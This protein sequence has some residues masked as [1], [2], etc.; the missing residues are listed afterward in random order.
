MQLIDSANEESNL[1][2]L[3]QMCLQ[4][5]DSAYGDDAGSIF[6]S[7]RFGCDLQ[8]PLVKE[9][10]DQMAMLYEEAE[11]YVAMLEWMNSIMNCL[12][13][14]F[15]SNAE[16]PLAPAGYY[17]RTRIIVLSSMP[18]DG[19]VESSLLYQGPAVFGEDPDQPAHLMSSDD[20][21]SRYSIA[22]FWGVTSFLLTFFTLCICCPGCFGSKAVYTHNKKLS[23]YGDGEFLKTLDEVDEELLLTDKE[24][25]EQSR[26][27]LLKIPVH[28]I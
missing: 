8:L 12:N 6:A 18:Q 22:I 20:R 28:S 16:R 4:S 26:V 27:L 21:L 15:Q 24:G 19:T 13:H 2:V 11:Q 3:L 9:R 5:C 14:R 1:D 10:R 17:V 23:I 7:C 25:I